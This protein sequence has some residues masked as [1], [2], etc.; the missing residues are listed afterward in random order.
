[1]SRRNPFREIERVLDRINDRFDDDLGAELGLQ[2]IPVDVHDSGDAFVVTADLPGFELDDIEVELLD[3]TVSIE[4]EQTTETEAED[5]TGHYIRQE[6]RSESVSRTVEL[7]EDVDVDAVEATF[8][9]GVLT[10][11]LPKAA[12]VGD[13]HTIDVE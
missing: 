4:A 8:E 12:D 9:N 1:M 13:A 6:R 2:G 7:P 3:Q 5:V 11:T 10:V